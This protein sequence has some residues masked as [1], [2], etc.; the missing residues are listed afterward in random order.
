MDNGLLRR[1]EFADTL[2]LLRERLGLNVI[3]VDASD[4][5]LARLKGVADPGAKAQNH[6]R[7]IHFRFRGRSS[8]SCV[9]A[10]RACP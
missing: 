6:R 7:G 2:E 1:N 4:R 5:F 9:D 10:S 8:A 3:G